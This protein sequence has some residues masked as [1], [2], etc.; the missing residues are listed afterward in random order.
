MAG[1][2]LSS[3]AQSRSDL[4]HRWLMLALLC[5]ALIGS[6]YVYDNPTALENQVRGTGCTWLLG[7][8]SHRYQP[9]ILVF[10][11]AESIL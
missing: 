1:S 6:Y 10:F 8:A 3:L 5:T 11:S 9:P 4:P 7:T 2:D